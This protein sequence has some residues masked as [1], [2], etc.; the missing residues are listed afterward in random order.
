M[1]ITFAIVIIITS[2]TILIIFIFA[3][4][5]YQFIR[6]LTDLVCV[7]FILC[8]A[9]QRKFLAASSGPSEATPRTATPS[10]LQFYLQLLGEEVA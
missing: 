7:C 5:P 2:S 8:Q 6:K 9:K 4:L 3:W 10:S 1:I